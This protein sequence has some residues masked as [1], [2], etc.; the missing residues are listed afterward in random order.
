[1]G[2]TPSDVFALRL[3]PSARITIPIIYKTNL[4]ISIFSNFKKSHKTAYNIGLEEFQQS[5]QLVN[6]IITG[7]LVACSAITCQSRSRFLLSRWQTGSR[8]S[9]TGCQ[10]FRPTGRFGYWL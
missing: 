2:E 5:E 4:F 10:N 7:G 8:Q 3:I 9:P 1:M 6:V